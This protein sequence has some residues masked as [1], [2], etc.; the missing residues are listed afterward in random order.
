M[1]GLQNWWIYKE[2]RRNVVTI[3][4]YLWSTG[5]WAQGLILGRQVLYH[6]S[7]AANSYKAPFLVGVWFELRD[8]CCQSRCLPLEQM[9]SLVC[10]GYFGDNI[11]QTIR[12]W[13]PWHSILSILVSKAAGMTSMSHQ[14][15]PIIILKSM[16]G[17]L[18]LNWVLLWWQRKELDVFIPNK[19]CFQAKHLYA[20]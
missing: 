14:H 2:M 11:S 8:S 6:L 4:M 1:K 19:L 18:C 17:P 12:A 16:F 20:K 7:H 5:R 15:Q 13:C 9:S 10:S 3:F